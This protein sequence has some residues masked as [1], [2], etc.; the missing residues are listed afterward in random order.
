M[1]WR[2]KVE[3]FEEIR[4]EYEFGV[5]TILGVARKL[6]VHRR[7]VREAIH[8]A[9]PVRRKKTDRPRTT[10]GPAVAFIE[11]ILEADRKAPRKQRHT[12]HRIWKRINEEV[13]GCTAAERTVRQYVEQRKQELGLAGRETFVPQSYDWGIEAQV[14]WYEAYAD[15]DGERVKLQ[16]FSLRSMASGAVYHRAYLR[17]TQQAFLEGHELAFHYF[18]GVFRRV[19]YDNLASAVKKILRGYER[20]LTARF[21]AFRSHWQYQAD[22]CTPGEGHEKGG[23][24]GEVGYFRRNHWVPIP[25]ASDLAELNAK[26]LADCHHDEKRIIAGRQES[27]GALL[28]KEK[29]HLLPLPAEDFELAEVSFPKVDQAGCAKVLTNFYSVPL[30]AGSVVE[31]RAYSSVIEFRQ[32]GTAVAQHQRSY[33]RSQQILDLEHYLEVLERKPGALRGSKPLAQW[34]AQGRWPERYDQLWALLNQKYGRQG[35]TRSILAII[36]MGREFGYAKLE[37]SVTQALGLGCTDGAAIRHLLMSD[38]LQHAAATTIALGA[39]AAY[40]RPL[41]TMT[42]YNQLLTIEVSA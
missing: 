17:A 36:R 40:E 16:V 23:V 5:G 20:E 9:V 11:E 19:R 32:N 38:Q 6:G 21:I 15:L 1:D 18:G 37:T 29:E 33:A 2:A 30:T 34:R 7:M 39:L 31:A 8:S 25:G 10:M 27:V 13:P 26:L 22:F 41:P 4:R 14:D 3:I 12:A 24:E 28:L 35:G 42:E